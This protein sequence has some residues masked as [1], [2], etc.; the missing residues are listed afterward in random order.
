MG[1]RACGHTQPH[2]LA[3][4]MLQ[5]QK[6]IQQPKRDRWDYEQIHRRNAVGMIAQKGLPAL[7]RWPPSPGH[8]FCHGGLPDIDAKLEQFAV[9][10]WRSPKRVS[11]AHVTDE[12]ANVR[13]CLWPATARSRFPA[14]ISSEP[15]AVPADHRLR[16]ENFQCVQYS[17]S[18]TIERG[19][20]K[21]VNVTERQPLWGFSP[22]HVELMSKD[23]DLGFQRSPRPEQSDQGT[24]DQP[25]KVA[26][27]ERVSA[28]SRRPISRFGFA[29][30]TRFGFAVGTRLAEIAV[31]TRLAATKLRVEIY[32][33][34]L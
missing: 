10:P 23:K 15:S 13:R 5:D 26:H 12:L 4:G 14:L 6:S 8:V 28:D 17:R 22:Q 18:H 27:R 1:V 7:R 19:K 16:L 32:A 20:H 33:K 30:G 25:T 29:V 31:G 3:A 24:P 2:K 34:L 11:D 9:H 21:A